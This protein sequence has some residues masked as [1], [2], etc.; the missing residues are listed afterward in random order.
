MCVCVIESEGKERGNYFSSITC[1]IRTTTSSSL[2]NDNNTY[3]K[4][5]R[6]TSNN[7]A[8]VCN[9]IVHELYHSTQNSLNAER[10]SYNI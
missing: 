10:D 4:N 9:K 6:I 2:Y 7:K 1:P 5:K 8:N 3:D